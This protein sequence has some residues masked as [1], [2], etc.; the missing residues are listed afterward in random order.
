MVASID[1]EGQ[2]FGWLVVLH[3]DRTKPK[4]HAWWMCLCK[5]GNFHSVK[6]YDLRTGQTKSCGCMR[7]TI[8]I[9]MAQQHNVVHGLRNSP[10]YNVWRAMKKRCSLKSSQGYQRYGGRGITVCDEWENS[11]QAFYR[12]MGPRPSPSHSID[13]IDNDKG[14][15]P[16]NC[17]WAT[18]YDQAN[19][20]SNNVLLTY[21]GEKR[22]LA[23]CA[24]ALNLPRARLY[25]RRDAGWSDDEILAGRSA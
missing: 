14:Y 21:Q 24:Q 4:G 3:R 15:S 5:C 6:S 19:N 7:A 1:I 10:E 13:R 11:F 12:D 8:N 9:S 2:I 16:E 22:T 20:K 23:Q 18:I 25:K 17:R